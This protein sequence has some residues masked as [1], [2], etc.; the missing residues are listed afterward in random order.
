MCESRGTV[1]ISAE[2]ASTEPGTG[3]ALREV[4][5]CRQRSSVRGKSRSQNDSVL[6]VFKQEQALPSTTKAM[7]T[8]AGASG[9]A[10]IIAVG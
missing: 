6:F 3:T 9:L 4:D 1:Y 10:T 8:G 5:V 7:R 2:T